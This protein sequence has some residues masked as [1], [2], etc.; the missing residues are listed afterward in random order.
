MIIEQFNN[1]FVINEVWYAKSYVV[2]VHLLQ[3]LRNFWRTRLCWRFRWFFRSGALLLEL[4]HEASTRV[5]EDILEGMQEILNYSQLID[6][7]LR[8]E[9]VRGGR[10]GVVL[11]FATP[12]PFLHLYHLLVQI[13]RR[14]ATRRG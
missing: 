11:R 5:V 12:L 7:V 13:I 6:C 8:V 10:D 2:I 4:L 1:C 14:P 9:I 3:V